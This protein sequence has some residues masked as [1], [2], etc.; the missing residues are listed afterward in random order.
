MGADVGELVKNLFGNQ[1]MQNITGTVGKYGEIASF[2]TGFLTDDPEIQKDVKQLAQMAK[3]AEAFSKF[4][5][6][7]ASAPETVGD[8]VQALQE[9]R[10]FRDA[11]NEG[12]GV[13]WASTKALFISKL[14]GWIAKKIAGLFFSEDTPLAEANKRLQQ[15]RG[16]SEP[17]QAGHG[18]GAQMLA[19][20]QGAMKK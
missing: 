2:L 8:M 7:R 19:A 5:G 4:L 3:G 11:V 13:L 17:E 15:A 12:D 6:G 14:E 9:Y 10:I 1:T 20:L 18:L 16:A